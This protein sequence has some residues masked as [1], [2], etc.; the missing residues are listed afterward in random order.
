MKEQ[1]QLTD[2]ALV[3]Q[4]DDSPQYKHNPYRLPTLLVLGAIVSLN[5]KG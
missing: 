2:N 4:V 5:T 3:F 1:D